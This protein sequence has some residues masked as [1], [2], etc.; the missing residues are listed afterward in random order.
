ME[1]PAPKQLLVNTSTR[2]AG[3]RAQRSHKGA[4][5]RSNSAFQFATKVFERVKQFV[6]AVIPFLAIFAQR[7]TDDLLKLRREYARHTS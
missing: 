5:A 2:A 1:A 3:D 7:F 4:A 6:C